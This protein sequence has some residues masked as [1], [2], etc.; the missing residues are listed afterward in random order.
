MGKIIGFLTVSLLLCSQFALAEIDP[1]VK[2]KL[3]ELDA[4]IKNLQELEPS[5]DY[6]LQKIDNELGFL[7]AEIMVLKENQKKR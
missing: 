5:T 4:K 1:E 6:R 7:T 2:A 3:D